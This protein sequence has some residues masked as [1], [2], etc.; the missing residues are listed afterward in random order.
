MVYRP[1]TALSSEDAQGFLNWHKKNY[2]KK[3]K[4]SRR[5]M[6]IKG[7]RMGTRMCL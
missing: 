6:G 2:I 7:S 1:G 5:Q 3:K 4:A